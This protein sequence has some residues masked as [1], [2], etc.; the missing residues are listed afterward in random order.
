MQKLADYKLIIDDIY[1]AKLNF[2]PA[3]S[4]LATKANE[5]ND[6]SNLKNNILKLAHVFDISA[7]ARYDSERRTVFGNNLEKTILKESGESATA[8]LTSSSSHIF[9]KAEPFFDVSQI[10]ELF[11]N[12]I[13]EI[14]E[15]ISNFAGIIGAQF[16]EYLQ[17]VMAAL[18]EMTN[19][20]AIMHSMLLRVQQ[21]EEMHNNRSFA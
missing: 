5:F 2:A 12:I 20:I 14:K 11:F 8:L 13:D 7:P 18:H 15:F 9:S 17:K 1:Q 3:F 6:K 10:Q 4:Y 19:K 16:E 21:K